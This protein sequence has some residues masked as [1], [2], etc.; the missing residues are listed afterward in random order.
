MAAIVAFAEQ[1]E[2]VDKIGEHMEKQSQA[3]DP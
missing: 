1:P 3:K 2:A